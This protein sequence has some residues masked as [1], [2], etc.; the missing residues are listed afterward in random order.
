MNI[1]SLIR[2]LLFYDI[3]R[4][5]CLSHTM[6]NARSEEIESKPSFRD[7]FKKRRCLVFTDGFYEWKKV[8][9]KTKVPYFIRLKSGKPFAFAGL[10]DTW[11]KG[12]EPLV[13]FTII[14]TEN[15]EL[16]AP[17]HNSMPVIL[18]EKDE[19]LWL[20]PELKDP[21]KLLPLLKPYPSKGMKLNE[22]STVV[23]SLKNDVSECIEPV[24]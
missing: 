12:K 2:S 23:N 24:S 10:W 13:T 20:D 9:T 19:G 7:P 16:I 3:P 14:T 5:N 4:L 15:N 21:K 18:H 6:I 22:V 1:K 17:I 11:D 8:D